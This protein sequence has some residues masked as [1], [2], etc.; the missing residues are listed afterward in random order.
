MV[1][2]EVLELA[3]DVAVIGAGSAGVRAAIETAKQGVNVL[4]FS[5]GPLGKSGITPLI[6]SGYT[7]VTG[8][9]AEDTP[10]Q[11]WEDTVTAGYHLCDQELVWAMV[12]DG[13]QTVK[14]LEVFG[15]RFRK[16][17]EQYW[18]WPI[19]PG[20]AYPRMLY[21]TGGGPAYMRA[22]GNELAKHSSV[23]LIEDAIVT[24][25]LKTD[26]RVSGLVAID[27]RV[28]N[29]L[30]VSCKAVVL[31]TGGCG[32]VFPY[33][34]CPPESTGDGYSLALEVGA[35]LV[36]ME[37]QLFYPT[38]MIHPRAVFGLEITYEAYLRPGV[39]ILN[40]RGEE[41]LSSG[42]YPTRAE[43][44][45]AIFREIS[46]GRG[47][48][49]GGVKIDLSGCPS[50]GKQEIADLLPAFK[51]LLDCGIDIRKEPLEVAPG[52][53]T[54]LG[55]VR[56][57]ENTRTKVPGLF[58][59]GEVAGNVHGA[60]RLAGN[61]L[62]DTQSFGQ[63]AGK[64]ALEYTADMGFPPQSPDVEMEL[65]GTGSL[66][67]GSAGDARPIEIK[68]QIHNLMWKLVGLR[69]ERS[70]LEKALRELERLEG[71]GMTIAPGQQYNYEWMEAF[72]TAHMF[73]VARAIVL[74]CLARGESRGTHFRED[75][76]EASSE[77]VRHTVVS[78]R[79]ETMLS[80][81]TPVRVLSSTP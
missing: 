38:V 9:V 70:K 14:D 52:A 67:P 63:R 11:H 17:G 22:L 65:E 25:I 62:L 21:I 75:F 78:M 72:E 57:D 24:K 74:G 23:R 54:T 8:T 61:A 4:V 55:G 33:T 53:H 40:G 15:L 59:C 47:T 41:F 56:I 30:L 7:A 76:P 66:K 79:D 18:F 48:E 43:F 39:R 20:M 26:G 69:R 46:S 32:Q 73:K 77:P 1:R 28:G 49:H 45:N 29:L 13:P 42:A 50:E 19:A 81:H 31:A 10:E 68:R 27:S 60:N 3:A 71:T 6:F 35:E 12:S 34:D 37:Q 5:K 44:A 80:A 16:D 51:R 58:A 64:A 2:S 36:D